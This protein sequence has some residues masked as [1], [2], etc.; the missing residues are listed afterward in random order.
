[1]VNN[2]PEWQVLAIFILWF[3]TTKLWSGWSVL[4][5]EGASEPLEG[6]LKYSDFWPYSR[7]LWLSKGVTKECFKKACHVSSPANGQ[8]M[9]HWKT[10][11]VKDDAFLFASWWVVCLGDLY[12]FPG[13]CLLYFSFFLVLD[14]NTETSNQMESSPAV[15]V[16]MQSQAKQCM[17][18][19]VMICRKHSTY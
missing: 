17:L 13:M 8:K 15:S 12:L 9:K 7:R 3:F 4:R 19:L 16:T 14:W 5:L 18:S 10:L 1:M 6:L 11:D 2:I